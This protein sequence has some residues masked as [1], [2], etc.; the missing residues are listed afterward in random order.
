MKLFRNRKG[1][2]LTEYILMLAL[3]A[4]AAISAVMYFSD[5]LRDQ[6]QNVSEEV[7]GANAT[8]G[9]SQNGALAASAVVEYN[10]AN[11]V[12]VQD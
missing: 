12:N 9:D 8:V 3:V 2:G 4:I 7:L 6:F 1:Q 11:Y 5:N 10:M